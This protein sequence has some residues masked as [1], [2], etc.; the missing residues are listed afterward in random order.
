MVATNVAAD[1]RRV[2]SVHG[3]SQD[4]RP[5]F[6]LD[7]PDSEGGTH[8]Q[9]IPVGT[10]QILVAWTESRGGMQRVRLARLRLASE[11]AVAGGAAT[12]TLPPVPGNPAPPWEGTTLTG[13]KVALANYRNAEQVVLLNVWA[14][15]CTPCLREMPGL[16]ALHR[17]FDGK[18]VTVVGASVDRR[19]AHADVARFVD[20]LGISFPILVDPDQNVMRQ[21]RTI[22][23]PETFLIDAEGII[24]HRW[25][26]EFDPMEP[27][28][29]NRVEAL[30]STP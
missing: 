8:P 28:V 14:T 10:G 22:G 24:R 15:W 30:L 29:L 26:G 25:I 6:A 2:I 3:V 23:V 7:I 4:G 9:I 11:R 27:D 1:G 21:F 13:E 5:T 12:P 17:H 19:A 16:E 18:G 20:D